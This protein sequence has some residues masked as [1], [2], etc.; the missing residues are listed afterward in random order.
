MRTTSGMSRAEFD[1]ARDRLL[2]AASADPAL[3]GVLGSGYFRNLG[4]IGQT[5]SVA[6]VLN[7]A[8]PIIRQ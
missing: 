1:A 8:E 2:A 4:G 7:A 5:P 6:E 3:T